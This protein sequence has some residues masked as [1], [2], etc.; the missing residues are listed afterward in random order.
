MN[1]CHN[2]IGCFEDRDWP[3]NTPFSKRPTRQLAPRSAR[4]RPMVKLS[5]G[6]GGPRHGNAANALARRRRR[7]LAR[8]SLIAQA[9]AYNIYFTILLQYAHGATDGVHT[10]CNNGVW[11]GTAVIILC[12][13]TTSRPIGETRTYAH[14]RR[15]RERATVHSARAHNNIL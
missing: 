1:I 14:G 13:L 12:T 4:R 8:L 6:P 3:G 7:S 10:R 5:V 2:N 15:M 9:A 11:S